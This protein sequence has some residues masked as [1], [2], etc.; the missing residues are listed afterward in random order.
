MGNNLSKPEERTEP[1]PTISLTANHLN[2]VNGMLQP[3]PAGLRLL[4][5]IHY[6]L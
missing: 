6:S 2:C 3:V 1:L 5:G 4:G